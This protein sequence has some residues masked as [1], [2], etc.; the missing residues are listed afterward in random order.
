MNS[1]NFLIIKKLDIYSKIRKGGQGEN[2]RN[3]DQIANF[4]SERTPN[5]KR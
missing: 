3:V 4:E 1:Q 5:G 2:L